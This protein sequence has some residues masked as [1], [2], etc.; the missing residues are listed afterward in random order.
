MA[1]QGKPLPAE[2]LAGLRRL[3]RNKI[4][5]AKAARALGIS[6]QTVWRHTKG[7]S[8]PPDLADI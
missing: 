8:T 3:L 1:T 6:R 7:R 4:P 2:I 5:K